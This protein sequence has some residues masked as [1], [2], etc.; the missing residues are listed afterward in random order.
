MKRLSLLT[1]VF[2]LFAFAAKAQTTSTNKVD[3]TVNKANNSVNS[4]NN[5]VN[6]ASATGTNAVNT[7]TNATNSAKNLANQVG[8][9]FGKKADSGP[10]N[11]TQIT[12]KNATFA[13]LKK[14]NEAI[15]SC[16]G[17]QDS[18]MKFNAAESTITVLHSGST[19]KLLQVI[20][21]KSDMVPDDAIEN[22]D[23]GV[24]ALTLK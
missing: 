5:S 24:I 22:V 19:T 20:Q 1:L 18:K 6:N 11:T 8:G 7:A 17:V 15:Q 23:E 12:V 4:A 10:A 21:K 16:S 9:L 2:L 14:L 3:N 13:K